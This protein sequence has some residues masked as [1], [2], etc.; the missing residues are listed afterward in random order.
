MPSN[1]SFGFFILIISLLFMAYIYLTSSKILISNLIISF[2]FLTI[3]ITRPYY[4]YP[5][6]LIW[7]KFGYFLSVIFSPVI[8]S[9]IYFFVIMPINLLLRIFRKD[10][11]GLKINKNEKSFWKKPQKVNESINYKVEF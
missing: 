1:K 9:L 5:L 3:T 2:L 4:L 11:L 6:N 7:Y 8:L 10:P